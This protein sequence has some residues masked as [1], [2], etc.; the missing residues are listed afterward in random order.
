MYYFL[1]NHG[2][3]VKIHHFSIRLCALSQTTL[4]ENVALPFYIYG[5][6]LQEALVIN[7]YYWKL[8]KNIFSQKEYRGSHFIV[9]ANILI[10]WKVLQ[11]MLQ[12]C[13]HIYSFVAAKFWKCLLMVIFDASNRGRAILSIKL[14]SYNCCV[15]WELRMLQQ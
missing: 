2:M 4:N 9:L 11:T 12:L 8:Y 13:N 3:N 15:C 14:K 6:I 10:H 5:F 1:R 7:Y